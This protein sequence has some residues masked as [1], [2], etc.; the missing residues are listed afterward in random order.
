MHR[1]VSAFALCKQQG[2]HFYQEYAVSTLNSESY[3]SVYLL[4][5]L[6]NEFGGG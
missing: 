2:Q 1:L 5:N 4:L 3:I 6:F